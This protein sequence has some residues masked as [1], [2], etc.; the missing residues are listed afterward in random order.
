MSLTEIAPS[1]WPPIATGMICP[2]M[3]TV[4]QHVTRR[5]RAREDLDL[6]VDQ[7]DDPVDRDPRGPVDLGGILPIV[8]QA[9]IGDLDHQRDVARPGWPPR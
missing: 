4:A 2:G 3:K 7:V 5:T 6:A 1:C 8:R 9:R